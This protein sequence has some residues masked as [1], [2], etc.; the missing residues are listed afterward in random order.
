V[1]FP[2]VGALNQHSESSKLLRTATSDFDPCL[3]L[4]LVNFYTAVPPACAS[5]MVSSARLGEYD[6]CAGESLLR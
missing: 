3:A 4:T 2:S 1:D 5:L 6:E